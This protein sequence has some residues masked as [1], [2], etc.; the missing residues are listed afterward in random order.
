MSRDNDGEI[1]EGG[2]I[3][4]CQG[5]NPASTYNFESNATQILQF[6]VFL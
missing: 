3:V 4:D 2:Q 1:D 6:S 5:S